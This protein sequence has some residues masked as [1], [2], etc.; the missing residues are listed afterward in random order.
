[1]LYWICN[2][3]GIDENYLLLD[4]WMHRNVCRNKYKY[5]TVLT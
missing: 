3:T 5:C 1:M 4:V 2:P